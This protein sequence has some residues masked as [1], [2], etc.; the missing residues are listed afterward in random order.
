MMGEVLPIDGWKARGIGFNS[1]G[2][3]GKYKHVDM[4]YLHCPCCGEPGL[5]IHRRYTVRVRDLP[6]G[7]H[8]STLEIEVFEC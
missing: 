1:K 3:I 5:T 6:Q 8:H 2:C 7:I 4:S